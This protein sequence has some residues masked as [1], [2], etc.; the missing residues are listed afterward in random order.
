MAKDYYETLGINR[1]ADKEEIKKAFRKLAH[2]YHPDKKG[3]DEKKFKEINEAY[4]VLS[5]DKKKAEYDSYGRVFSNSNG[6][7]SS[8]GPFEWNFSDF[9]GT[10]FENFDL[11]DIFGDF[12]GGQREKA[13]GRDIS[14]D[15]EISFK[16]SVFGT[17]RRVLL[18]KTAICEDCR[19]NGAKAGTKLVTCTAC[20]GQGKVRDVKKSFFGTMSVQRTCDKC[21]G[22]GEVPKEKCPSCFGLGIKK[23]SQEITVNVPSGIDDGEMIRMVGQGEVVSSGAAGD[24]YVKIHVK[25]DSRYRKEGS[26]LVTDLNIKLTDA[27]LGGEYNLETLDGM[28][29]IKIPENISLGEILRIKGK[30]VPIDKSRRGDLYIKINIELPKKLSKEAKKVIERLRQEG[31]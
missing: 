22:R 12:F 8:Q 23:K 11:G 1:N 28:V 13:R 5:D 16:E 7:G 29:K 26:N 20:N 10:N 17:Q 19:G 24:L 14:I 21:N 31:I 2:K 6:G 9:E 15:I 4:G 3:G 18:Q 25:K 27:L 30:G